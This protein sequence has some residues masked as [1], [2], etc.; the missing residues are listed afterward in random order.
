MAVDQA[1][2]A[3]PLVVEVKML[4]VARAALAARSPME[5]LA[6]LDH[7]AASYPTG[8]LRLEATVLRI[9]ALH[10]AGRIAEA[11]ALADRFLSAHGNGPL[12]PRVHAILAGAI[13]TSR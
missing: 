2:T 7:Y 9:E 3:D 11:S 1:P 5:A 13:E 10:R 12:A 8:Q 6:A 4:A